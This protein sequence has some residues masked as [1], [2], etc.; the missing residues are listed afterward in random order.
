ME[1]YHCLG[2]QPPILHNRLERMPEEGYVWLDFERSEAQGW[3]SWPRLLLGVEV[4]HTQV[5]DSMTP[6][7]SS[8]FDG[9]EDYDMLIF[10]GLGPKDDPFP[11]DTRTATFFVFERLLITVRAEDN[12]SFQ[13]VKQ[14]LRGMKAKAPPSALCLAH[15]VLDTMVNRFLRVRESLS[16]RLTEL[17][18]ELLSPD[19][20]ME[21]W[22][23]LLEGRRMV[24]RLEAL[25]EDQI[26]ALDA[27][28][29]GTC[30]DWAG[31]AEVRMRDLR[32]HVSRV[33][34]HASGMERDLEAAVQLYFA[35]VSN[36]TNEIM[37]VFT[38]LA[39]VFMPLT[40]LTG[41]W[42][43]NFKHM[44][45]LEWE[46]GYYWALGLICVIGFGM[47]WWFRRSKFF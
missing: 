30:L 29:R 34:D 47:F 40:L 11:L 28:R 8:Y 12:L 17:Q 37:K 18:D 1:I 41:I 45:E 6:D 36:R 15:Q 10:E 31:T 27:W 46:Y 22:H 4:D 7:H 19:S 23:A 13:M 44:P 25:S 20:M 16:L 3:E 2:G 14:K 5:V 33:R 24:R 32:E 43:M 9:T 21:D 26:E 39:V 42:G 35:R 38:V